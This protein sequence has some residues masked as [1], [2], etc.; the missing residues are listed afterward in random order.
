MKP[1]KESNQESVVRDFNFL[2]IK[3]SIMIELATMELNDKDE[4]S[5][6]HGITGKLLI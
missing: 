4:F 2:I 6:L 1:P 5:R 3:E